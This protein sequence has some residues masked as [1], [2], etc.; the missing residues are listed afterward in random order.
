MA[1]KIP[2]DL[3]LS[4]FKQAYKY[5]VAKSCL[6]FTKCSVSIALNEGVAEV[7]IRACSLFKN[8]AIA[9]IEMNPF[10]L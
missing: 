5:L 1:E 3:F 2:Y 7:I 8:I 6:I 9:T 4:T 10:N